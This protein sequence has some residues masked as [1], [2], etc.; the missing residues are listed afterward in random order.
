MERPAATSAPTIQPRASSHAQWVG[1]K[2]VRSRPRA[3]RTRLPQ[4]GLHKE[5]AEVPLTYQY[6]WSGR[7]LLLLPIF[8]M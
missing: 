2:V 6:Q 8:G 1:W 4:M 7:Q 5:V 3:V